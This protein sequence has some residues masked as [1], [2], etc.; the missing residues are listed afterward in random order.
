M[1]QG[2]FPPRP[3]LIQQLCI[4]GDRVYLGQCPLL[5]LWLP[6]TSGSLLMN[7]LLLKA[8]DHWRD[9]VG[10]HNKSTELLG[11][12]R[13]SSGTPPPA[14]LCLGPF[15]PSCLWGEWGEIRQWSCNPSRPVSGF[16]FS[17]LCLIWVFLTQEGVTIFSTLFLWSGN[18]MR[19]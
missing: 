2:R 15:W 7:M 8:E 16:T 3:Q 11:G 12:S 13:S 19:S 18:A 9:M 6:H 4:C 5:I 10:V 1:H 14:A 17:Y